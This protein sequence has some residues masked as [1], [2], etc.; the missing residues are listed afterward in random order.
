MY[1]IMLINKTETLIFT[2]S[3]RFSSNPFLNWLYLSLR[4]GSKNLAFS[5]EAWHISRT[6]AAT[7]LISFMIPNSP[8]YTYSYFSIISASSLNT[9]G[10]EV[11]KAL[12]YALCL[13]ISSVRKLVCS[14]SLRLAI[15]FLLYWR[16][17][18][19]WSSLAFTFLIRVFKS[20]CRFLYNRSGF[21]KNIRNWE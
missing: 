14:I 1:S 21:P 5:Y 15:K 3:L 10:L 13:F 18:R 6:L 8:D 20:V 19:Y 17:V 9:Y 11:K 4:H 16:R 12:I 2:F 7:L